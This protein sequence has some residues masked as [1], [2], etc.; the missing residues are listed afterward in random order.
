M[1]TSN[2]QRYTPVDLQSNDPE[3][4][5][6]IDEAQHASEPTEPKS[7]ININ[8]HR[9]PY[10]IVWTHLPMITSILPVIGHTGICTSEGVI[11]DFAGSYYISVDNFA[12]GDPHKYVML[13]SEGIDPNTWDECVD[14]ADRKFRGQTHNIFTNNC[15][16]HVAEVLNQV[17]YK[18]KSNWNMVDIWWLIVKEGK[19]VR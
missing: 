18:G 5:L 10:C 17:K 4:I 7:D 1:A 12:F 15:H 11:H 9:Y 6:N 2:P 19:F 13:D 8:N 3:Q 16:S 14:K